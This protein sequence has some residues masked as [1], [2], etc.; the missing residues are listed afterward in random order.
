MNDIERKALTLVNQVERERAAN[1]H[2]DKIERIMRGLVMDEALCR[3]IEQH[4]AFKQDVSDA[5]KRLLKIVARERP[6]MQSDADAFAR[7]IITKADPDPDPLLDIWNEID[8]HNTWDAMDA[9]KFREAIKNR[10]GKIVW[11]DE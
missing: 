8:T 10:G 5:A 2:E 11:G 4:E 6:W 1:P 7:F 9:K 3:A